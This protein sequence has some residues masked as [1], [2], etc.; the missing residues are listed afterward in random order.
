MLSCLHLHNA[1]S[2]NK[3]NKLEVK[4]GRYLVFMKIKYRFYES[5]LVRSMQFLTFFKAMQKKSNLSCFE[6]CA[7]GEI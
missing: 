5:V 2:M 1:F 4:C 7:L 3:L 6:F